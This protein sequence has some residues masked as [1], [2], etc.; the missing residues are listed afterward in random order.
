M[1][2]GYHTCV[3]CADVKKMSPDCGTMAGAVDAR[4]MSS[5]LNQQLEYASYPVVTLNLL[6]S[7]LNFHSRNENEYSYLRVR[8][9]KQCEMTI[10]IFIFAQ[11]RN[12]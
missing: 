5:R 1:A 6:C 4:E 12:C 3:E 7:C 2:A 9:I 8:N 10:K 11:I